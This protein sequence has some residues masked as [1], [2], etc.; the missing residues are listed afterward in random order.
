[1]AQNLARI[2]GNDHV[3]VITFRRQAWLDGRPE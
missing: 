1:V 3:D 2:V